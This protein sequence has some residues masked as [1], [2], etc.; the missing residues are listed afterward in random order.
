MSTVI[1]TPLADLVEDLELYPRH[2]VDDANV[3]RLALALEAGIDLPPIVADRKSKRIVDGWHRGR[4]YR[5]VHGN[6]ATVPVEFRSYPNEAALV[7]DAIHMNATHGRPFD[8][9][10]RTRAVLM[11]ERL[12]LKPER[13][14]TALSCPVE[15]VEKLRL[16]VATANATVDATVPGTRKVTLKRPM[17]HFAGKTL[18][19]PQA[20]A[21]DRAPGTSYLLV[22]RQL[23]DAVRLNLYA[24]DDE[25]I[26]KAFKELRKALQEA[27][28]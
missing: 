22:A 24:P 8:E 21:H 20:E 19:R 14:A 25:K 17:A 15:K 2:A 16:R 11:L 10:D 28:F 27:G 26:G 12:G 6:G 23:L 1:Q 5:R 9:M 4:A 3:A 13:I 7:E 18:T